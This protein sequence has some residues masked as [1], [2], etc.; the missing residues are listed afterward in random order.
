LRG[1]VCLSEGR[2]LEALRCFELAHEQEPLDPAHGSYLGLLLGEQRGLH[3]RAVELCQGAVEAAPDRTEFRL[4]LV[5]V[6][7]AAGRKDVALAAARDGLQRHPQHEELR[8]LVL[9]LGVRRALVFAGLPR[10]HP[11]N[12]YLGMLTWWL[13]MRS[14]PR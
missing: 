2:L 3:R 8:R 5:R 4:N 14:P 7:V 6:S 13:G 9:E 1:K 11:L 10:S 12:K